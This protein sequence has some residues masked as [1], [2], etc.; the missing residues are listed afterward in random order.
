MDEQNEIGGPRPEGRRRNQRNVPLRKRVKS[1]KFL[2]AVST[3]V[4]ASVLMLCD[5]IW[6]LNYVGF[7]EWAGFVSAIVIAYVGANVYQSRRYYREDDFYD[8]YPDRY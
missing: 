4:F 1:R 5:L 8:T 2:L 3:I 7:V 6:S